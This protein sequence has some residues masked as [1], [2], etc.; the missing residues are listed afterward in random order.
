MEAAPIPIAN[1]YFLLCY[2]WGQLE[3]GELVDVSH[4]QSPRLADLFASVLCSGVRHLARR[5][6]E[7]RYESQ[8]A[9]VSSPR[10]R[11]DALASARRFL[12]IHGKAACVYDE[13][14]VNTPAN[15]IVK[16]TLG[17]LKAS[18]EMSPELRREV[19]QAFRNLHPIDAIRVTAASFS[20]VQLHANTRFYRF[21]LNV[22]ELIHRCALPE[23][24]DGT[25]RFRDFVRDETAMARVFERFL[26]NFIARELKGVTVK[27][28]RI[29][30]M[31]SSYTD[32]TLSLLPGMNTDISVSS[33]GRRLI[34]DAKYYR[35]S[36]S[37]YYESA[38]LHSANLYQLMSYVSNA[39]ATHDGP[40]GGLLIYPRVDR[41][42]RE[43]YVIQRHNIF[44]G[45]ID[46]ARAWPHIHDE[47]LGLVRWAL[48]L[49]AK[50]VVGIPMPS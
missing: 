7:Q 45:T 14:T 8:A 29:P 39:A 17:V 10:G 1:L 33:P 40:V 48:L 12:P 6:L 27:R 15:Q 5:G 37:R 16:A 42:I 9:E 47:V 2:S 31:A 46:L 26:F 24:R 30:W 34:I 38:K 13:L 20:R 3:Q 43:A 18:D 41:E 19:A 49:E 36:L 28:D 21:L 11:I 35:Q 4:C 32:P 22:C 44:V 50:S 23:Q 25:V